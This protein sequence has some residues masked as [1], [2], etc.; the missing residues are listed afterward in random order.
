ML[1]IWVLF[2]AMLLSACSQT[3]PDSLEKGSPVPVADSIVDLR[4]GKTITPGELLEQLA[5]APRVIVGEKHDNASHHK[6][7]QWLVENLAH[8]RPLC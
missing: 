6:I 3:A 8:Q 5:A 1:K 2:S 4:S 7:E